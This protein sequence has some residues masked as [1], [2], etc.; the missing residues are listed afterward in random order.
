M[1]AL[2]RRAEQLYQEQDDQGQEMIQQMFL[3]LVTIAEQ[4]RIQIA[5][6]CFKNLLKPAGVCCMQELLSAAIEPD[7]LDEI[8]DTYVGYRL[9]TLDHDPATT[10]T[11]HRIGPRSHHCGPGTVLRRLA[12]GERKRPEYAPP[13]APRHK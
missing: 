12:G 9:L 8:I 10:K 4:T 5:G 7:R 3:R 13:A 2:A 6:L 11:D 1:G